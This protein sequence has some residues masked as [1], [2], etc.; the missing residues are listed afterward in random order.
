MSCFSQAWKD[1]LGTDN[2][3]AAEDRKMLRADGGRYMNLIGIV[4]TRAK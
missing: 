4:G 3:Y 1:W 2:P